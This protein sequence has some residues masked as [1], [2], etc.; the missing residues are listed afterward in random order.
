MMFKLKFC[1]PPTV[2][3][4]LTN[5]T[6]TAIFL[7]S[8]ISEVIAETYPCSGDFSDFV[9]D[10]KSEAVSQG[11]A[12]PLVQTFFANVKRDED[13]IRRDRN[14]GIF[15]KSF[16]EFS[17][18]VM[19]Q[20][21]I[22]KAAEF[23]HLHSEIFTRVKEKFGIPSGVLLS[24][25]ALE[26]DFGK[27][28]GDHNTINSLVTL[29]HDCRRPE[30]FRPHIFAAIE[31]NR[32]GSFNPETSIGAWAGEIGMIQMLP[33]DIVYFGQDGDADGKIDLK[34]SVADAL[35]TAGRVLSHFG[36][37][38]DQ[39]WLVE[40]IVPPNLPWRDTGLTS[41]KTVNEWLKLGVKVRNGTQ[42]DGQIKAS[43]LLPHGRKGP[44]FLTF[45]NFNIYFKWNQSS[46][47]TTTSAFF[48]TLLSGEP[49]YLARNSEPP[50][51]DNQILQLQRL[52]QKRG[53]DVG[54]IDGIIGRKT[55]AAIK[56]EQLR[57]GL[58][59]DEWPTAQLLKLINP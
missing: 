3:S 44:A 10:L 57:L 55:R 2:F 15:K 11:Y 20:Y 25:L 42:P 54:N 40:V 16:I 36:W 21:R 38:P 13:V 37:Q 45:P 35:M 12:E 1:L 41:K 27:V 48:A 29:A 52:L 19:S 43:I 51:E 58:P 31:L 28:Q 9:D 22:D 33:L 49:M 8:S 5:M 39:P 6:L 23:E 30:L 4:L 47:Y 17:T 14:Q 34:H 24:F 7:F 56:S 53:H 50:L 59:A 18:L 26:T 32:R 46:V